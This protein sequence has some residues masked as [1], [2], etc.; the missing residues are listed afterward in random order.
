MDEGVREELLCVL[1]EECILLGDYTLSAGGS[2]SYYVN[3]KS[4]LLSRRWL[5]L[6]TNVFA[7]WA[8]E[9][10]ADVVGGMEVGAIPL[11]V[12]LV[13]RRGPNGLDGFYVR[14]QVPSHGKR[15]RV[16]GNLRAGQRVLLVDDVITTGRSVME[17]AREVEALGC[18]VVGVACV[19][20]RLVG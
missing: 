12:G 5:L 8:G 17:A 18:K 3:L 13:S 15:G 7:G 4:V 9:W 20:D 19:V 2:S 14:K 16:E 6:I 11:V 10:G 1:R